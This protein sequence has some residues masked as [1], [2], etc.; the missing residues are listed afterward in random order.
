MIKELLASRKLPPLMSREEMLTVLFEKEYGYLP[1]LPEKTE[2]IVEQNHVPGVI[3]Y[4]N[5]CSGNAVPYKITGKFTVNGREFSFPFYA[6][7]PVSDEKHPFIISINFHRESPEIW[8]PTEEII[9]NGFALFH[10]R[11]T[12]ITCDANDFTDGLAGVLYEDGKRGPTDAGKIAMW[13]WAAQRVMDY[14]QTLDCL[15]FTCA[16]VC[17]HSR[18][19]KTALVTAAADERF[20]FCYSNDSGC[21]GAAI[22]RDKQGESNQ[23]IC[24]SCPH[25]FCE[26]YAQY[27]E[28][29]AHSLPFDQHWLI[30][31]IAPRYVLIGSAENDLW[32]DPESEFLSAAAASPAFEAAG[33]DGLIADNAIPVHDA[34]LPDGHIGYHIR[35]GEHYFGRVDWNR[36]MG[37]MKKHR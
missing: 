37:F 30:A 13:A 19:G 5:F 7:I 20:T 4:G 3:W 2:W 25:W 33:A 11:Y 14:A 21:S 29:G 24:T 35:P 18:L 27:M 34:Y 32:A 17:G 12:D 23:V 26:N 9:E 22:T 1:A 36:F 6:V 8:M 28:T 31:S 10:F 16:G 15:D